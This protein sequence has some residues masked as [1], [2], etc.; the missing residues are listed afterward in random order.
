MIDYHDVQNLSLEDL[1]ALALRDTASVKE[2]ATRYVTPKSL[3]QEAALDDLISVNGVGKKKAFQIMAMLELSRRII[4]SPPNGNP[5]I[6]C[7][8]EV[9]AIVQDSVKLL[10]REHFVVYILN[11]KN[12]ILSSE[13]AS[14]GSLNS[15]IVHPR[16]IFKRAVKISGA[17]IILV[18]NHPSGDPTPSSEDIAVTKRLVQ[19]GEV[20]GINVLDHVIIGSGKFTSLREIGVI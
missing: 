20:L 19:A 4:T 15:S 7:P 14:I 9:V 3:Y 1:L 2:L 18:H 6:T 13:V 8:T 17:S 5:V 12:R 10:D 16:E 11:Q